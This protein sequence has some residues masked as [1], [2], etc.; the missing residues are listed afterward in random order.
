M[1]LNYG[2][3]LVNRYEILDALPPYGQMA[4]PMVA[5]GE[6]F[7]SEGYVIKF[8]KD[9]GDF[10]IG[11]FPKGMTNLF[12]VKSY[13]NS[14]LILVISGGDGYLINPNTPKVLGRFEYMAL[15]LLEWQNNQLIL[16]T[17]DKV[18]I[19]DSNGATVWDIKLDISDGIK[20]LSIQD[21]ILYGYAYDIYSYDQDNP[22][23]KFQINLLT[24]ELLWIDEPF[25]YKPK[26][27]WI[28]KL[29]RLFYR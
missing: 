10:W 24:R 13:Q 2:A 4:I 14:P 26:I 1:D 9:D 3:I 8:Y 15:E 28:Q 6:V 22:W 5:D 12:D 17:Y 27:S 21:D 18:M 16:A 7:V 11:N 29:Y 25:I 20:D 23:I 19:I